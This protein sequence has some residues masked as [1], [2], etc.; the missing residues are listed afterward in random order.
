MAV[1]EEVDSTGMR[2]KLGQETITLPIT[3]DYQ[4]GRREK[5]KTSRNIAIVLGIVGI[6]VAIVLLFN[7]N[8]NI[9]TNLL[10]SAV[11]VLVV[12]F[13]I[14][15]PLLKEGTLREERIHLEDTD[16]FLPITSFWGIYDISDVYPYICRFRNGKSGVFILLNR[17]VIL[18]K[19][20]EAEFDHYEAIGDAYNISGSSNIQMCHLDYMDVVGS[21]ERL[22]ESFRSLLRVSNPD[23][24]DLL[25]DI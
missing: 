20:S 5:S 19:Y 17:D 10:M 24:K 12:S 9:F 25:I 8:G 11:V 23:L 13:I 21:D 15:F 7:K 18:G 14:R 16:G 22:D 1:R 4:G 6:I 2:P 3:F